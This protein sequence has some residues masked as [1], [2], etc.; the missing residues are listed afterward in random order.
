MNT[1]EQ[2]TSPSNWSEIE[3]QLLTDV[4]TAEVAFR[5]ATGDQKEEAGENYRQALARFTALILD[6]RF[7]PDIPLAN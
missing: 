6:R 7:P 3:V 5:L 1:L 4:R 2:T